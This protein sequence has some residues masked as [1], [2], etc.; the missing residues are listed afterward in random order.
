MSRQIYNDA[1]RMICRQQIDGKEI[2]WSDERDVYNA[3]CQPDE[4]VGRCVRFI[5]T[6]NQI[7]P[8]CFGK[9]TR[10]DIAASLNASSLFVIIDPIVSS[11]FAKCDQIFHPIR[12]QRYRYTFAQRLTKLAFKRTVYAHAK[13]HNKNTRNM[14]TFFTSNKTTNI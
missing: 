6:D 7:S 1:S 4:V 3:S 14:N 13:L 5:A 9:D 10:F 2:D 8:T 11:F 12:I